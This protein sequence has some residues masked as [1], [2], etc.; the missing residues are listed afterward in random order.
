MKM[1]IESFGLHHLQT[2]PLGPANRPPLALPLASIHHL[3]ITHQPASIHH[4]VQV[5]HEKPV[6]GTQSE[7]LSKSK[8]GNCGEIGHTRKWVKCPRY[9]SH[10]ECLRRQVFL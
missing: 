1:E 3:A 5:E 2:H 6:M 9:Y 8:C 10:E 4:P 7:A